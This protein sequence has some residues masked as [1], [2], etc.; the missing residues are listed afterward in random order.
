MSDLV[1][2]R[3][4]SV[5]LVAFVIIGFTSYLAVQ[6]EKEGLAKFTCA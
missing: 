1:L 4:R 3:A 6:V 5:L 2:P